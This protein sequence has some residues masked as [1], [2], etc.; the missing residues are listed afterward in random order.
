MAREGE[1]DISNLVDRLAASSV[2]H[3][4]IQHLSSTH[5]PNRDVVLWVLEQ[6]HGV[7]FPGFFGARDLTEE[8]LREHMHAVLF[9]YGSWLASFLG[10]TRR[11]T[12]ARV[13]RMASSMCRYFC[14][15]MA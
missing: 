14:V 15:A 7:L 3:D 4:R 2:E 10:S 9:V 1:S 5:L 12:T 13:V 11:S 8:N 6:L